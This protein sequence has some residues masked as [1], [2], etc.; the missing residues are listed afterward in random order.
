MK[1][2]FLRGSIYGIRLT[3]N[4]SLIPIQIRGTK[5]VT[6]DQNYYNMQKKNIKKIF[7]LTMQLIGV[8]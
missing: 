6:P 4:Y 2:Y 7:D 3:K 5:N 8:T 1:R